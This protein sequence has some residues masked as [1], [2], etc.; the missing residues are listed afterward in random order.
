MPPLQQ[1]ELE[2]DS[3]QLSSLLACIQAEW[4]IISTL[5]LLPVT[6]NLRIF[7]LLYT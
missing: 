1:L 7:S 4:F 5:K 3:P 6:I 2:G